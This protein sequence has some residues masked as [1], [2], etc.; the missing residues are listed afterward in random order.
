MLQ[1]KSLWQFLLELQ[2]HQQ[3]EYATFPLMNNFM[4][5]PFPS[6][7]VRKFIAYFSAFYGTLRFITVITWAF[8]CIISW[9]GWIQPTEWYHISVIS[10]LIFSFCL[11]VGLHGGLFPEGCSLYISH[12]PTPRS[13]AFPA[14]LILFDTITKTMYFSIIFRRARNQAKRLLKSLRLSV[15]G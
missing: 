9:A 14:H 8:H 10:L 6:S 5:W 13:T 12:S 1:H 11:S 7:K 2:L 15:F 4:N 3:L